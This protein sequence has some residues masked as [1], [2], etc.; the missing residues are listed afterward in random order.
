MSKDGN[1]ITKS[2]D[3]DFYFITLCVNSKIEKECKEK[4]NHPNKQFPH[5]E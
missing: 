1:G 2:I 3:P 4:K 5:I